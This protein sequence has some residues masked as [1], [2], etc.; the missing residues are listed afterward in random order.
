MVGVLEGVVSFSCRCCVGRNPC[1]SATK[2]LFG[3]QEFWIPSFAE[4]TEA[5]RFNSRQPNWT[6]LPKADPP[7]L[8]QLMM[9]FRL[10]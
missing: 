8:A 1:V 9:V 10:L 6:T 7:T 5:S 4:M 2:T 3:C